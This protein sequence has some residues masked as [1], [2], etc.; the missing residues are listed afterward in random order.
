MFLLLV[1]LAVFRLLH[2]VL[3]LAGLAMFKRLHFH[4]FRPFWPYSGGCI[5]ISSGCF[6]HVQTAGF[7]LLLA[8]LAM[9]RRLHFLFSA[10]LAMFSRPR[11][12]Y[13]WLFCPCS[14]GCIFLT[15]GRFGHIQTAAFL[16]FVANLAM[17]R[18]LHFYYF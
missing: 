3:F 6:G 7:L 18:Q 12:Y 17:F 16:L 11:F 15:P 8:V 2:F 13:F 1:V 4:Y 14:G 9:L 10:V 5:F